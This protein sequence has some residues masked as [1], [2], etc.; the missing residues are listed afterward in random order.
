VVDRDN[1]ARTVRRSLA[2]FTVIVI[3]VLVALGVDDWRQTGE[4]RRIERQAYVQLLE[5]LRLDSTDLANARM[6]AGNRTRAGLLLLERISLP[7]SEL[8]GLR[9]MLAD[10]LQFSDP[11]HL[12]GGVDSVGTELVALYQTLVFDPNR[13]ALSSLVGGGQLRLLRDPEVRTGLVSY[14]STVDQRNEIRGLTRDAQVRFKMYLDSHGITVL[15]LLLKPDLDQVLFGDPR[16]PIE[17]KATVYRAM[18]QVQDISA[19]EAER[20]WLRALVAERL[21]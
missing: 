10:A 7:E 4:E 20:A 11:S 6:R 8:S 14:S 13:S 5:D 19:I 2:E 21:R 16:L 1:L 18:V 15:D 3:G 12:V 17:I 9:S